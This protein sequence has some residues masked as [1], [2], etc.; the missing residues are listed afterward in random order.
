MVAVGANVENSDLRNRL[1]MVERHAMRDP[2]ASIVANDGESFM[3]QGAHQRD[4]IG[5]HRPFR[6]GGVIAA[7]FRLAA[8]AIAAQVGRYD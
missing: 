2:P 4:L 6:I 1:R 3:A 8:V 5:R 7:A